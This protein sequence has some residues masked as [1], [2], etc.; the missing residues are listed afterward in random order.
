MPGKQ[1]QGGGSSEPNGPNQRAGNASRDENLSKSE[2]RELQR[3]LEKIGEK[4]SYREIRE[5]AREIKKK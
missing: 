2:E 4:L 1:P 3:T 5:L